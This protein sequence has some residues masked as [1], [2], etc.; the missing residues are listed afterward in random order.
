MPL[1]SLNSFAPDSPLAALLVGALLCPVAA[2]PLMLLAGRYLKAG[3]GYLAMLA[4]L[5]SF[6]AL[7]GIALN[8]EPRAHLVFEIQWIPSLGVNLSFLIDGLSLFYGLIICGIGFL[9]CWYS[10]FYL[11]NEYRDHGLFYCY[12][13]VFI[14]AMLGTVFADN[15]VLLFVFWEITSVSSFLLIGFLHSEEESR[16]GARRALLVTVATGLCMLGGLVMLGLMGGSYS[17]SVLKDLDLGSTGYGN[18]WIYA[19]FL[20]I[21]IG[22]FGKSAQF[23][24]QFWLPGAMVAPTPVSTYL[25]SATMVKLGVFL[26]ARLFPILS[27]QELWFPVITAVCFFT[28]VLGAWLAL[29]SN[30]LKA[31][32]AWATVSQ[33]GFLIGFYG[34]GSSVGVRFD[35]LHIL[36]HVLYKAALFMVVGIVDHSTGIRDVRQLGG[37]ARRMPLTALTAAIGTAAFA[38]I[39]LT[40]GFISKETALTDMLGACAVHPVAGPI[41]VV[42]MVAATVMLVAVAA[43]IF[44]KVFLGPA[45]PCDD[46]HRPG[47][48][49]ELPPLVLAGLAIVLGTVPGL[50]DA[51][52]SHLQ[53]EGLHR[54]HEDGLHL[55]HGFS[56]EL[57][58]SAAVFGCAAALYWWAE[59]TQ[60]RWTTM[61]RWLRFDEAFDEASDWLVYAAKRLTH[62]LKADSPPA[63]V[64][65]VIMFLLL[66]MGGLTATVFFSANL[67]FGG[68]EIDWE[69]HPLRMFVV[70][71]ITIALLSIIFLRRWSAQLVALSVAG[72]FITLYFVLY[73]APDLAMTQ[74][75][76]ESATVVMIL[77]LLS[78]FPSYTQTGMRKD[79]RMDR[80][81]VFRLVVSLGVGALMSSLVI[82]AGLHRHPEPVGEQYLELSQPLAE[83]TNAVNTI[84]VDFRGFDTL[85]EITVLLTATL[86]GLGLMMRYKRGHNPGDPKPPP[87]FILGKGGKQ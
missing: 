13:M 20:L 47:L 76:V 54:I 34:L 83:G 37:L 28:M 46:F 12:L 80:R 65:I 45:I 66:V 7:L 72:F 52:L 78:R 25:H 18:G 84:L 43:R 36:S 11:N 31:I 77:F 40:T 24:F 56:I 60:W 38:G 26:T 41:L 62:M 5:A 87:G 30:D 27:Q 51:P 1:L 44:L 79:L 17:F 59:K 57:M 6:V 85:G 49:M 70:V 48:F 64:P 67:D 8:V 16:R 75:L 29:R 10:T 74:V 50:L 42:A 58:I 82:F 81:H 14:A 21:M 4:P 69:V 68:T 23:P 33:L 2:A 55:W 15:L 61:P 73:R 71:V 3:V 9:V 53:V 22:A 86:G 19:M 39:P 32:L 35:F 63:Y